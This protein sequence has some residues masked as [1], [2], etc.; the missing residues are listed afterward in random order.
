M[1][2]GIN[3]II[4]G[5][6]SIPIDT[7]AQVF[8][9][10]ASITDSTQKN[11]INQ[12]VTSLKL[13][14]I[15]SKMKAIYPFVGGTA[16]QHR[17]NL[18]SPG[19]TTGDFYLAFNGGGTHS[20]QGYLPDGATA[21]ANTWLQP[22]THISNQQSA[23]ISVYS[24]TNLFPTVSGTIKANGG[25][26]DPPTKDFQLGYWK[27]GGSGLNTYYFGTGGT[28]ALLID[29]TTP[30][31]KGFLLG[32]RTSSTLA[33]LYQDDVVI[34][35]TTTSTTAGLPSV[36]MLLGARN[37]NGVPDQYHNLP[38]QFVSIG[39]GLNDT[40][41]TALR[42]AVVTFNTTLNRQ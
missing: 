33:K 13:A 12:L 28:N 41:A 29:T 14:N 11:A 19:T 21:Y 37:A 24:N 27:R 42:N 22:S 23:H 31:S 40:E 9:T 25:Y 4:A 20:S 1:I 6:G 38:H 7:D 2:L 30:T 8:I 10:A 5:K 17:F 35:T 36:N 34:G 15:W 32:S 39:D 26:S 18:K 3:G 16:A